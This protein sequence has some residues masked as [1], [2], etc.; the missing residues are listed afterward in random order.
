MHHLGHKERDQWR[1]SLR[2]WRP[3]NHVELPT[4]VPQIHLHGKFPARGTARRPRRRADRE[5]SAATQRCHPDL[6]QSDAQMETEDGWVGLRVVGHH[7]A[8][9]GSDFDPRTYCFRKLSDLVRKT[10]A[11]DL[12]Q[13]EGG[14]CGLEQSRSKPVCH[15]RH[16]EGN[17]RRSPSVRFDAGGLCG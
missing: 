14:R 2:I 7:L 6:G 10:G 4:G 17:A 8:N 15:P 16:Q 3:K 9:I 13:R 11:F 5:G 1:R 12:D